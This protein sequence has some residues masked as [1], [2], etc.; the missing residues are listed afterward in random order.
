MKRVQ[1]RVPQDV[2]G[3]LARDQVAGGEPRTPAHVDAPTPN[4]RPT[5]P[6]NSGTSGFL[7][8]V[9][10]RGIGEVDVPDGG[11]VQA[12]SRSAAAGIG[13]DHPNADLSQPAYT[14]KYMD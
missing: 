4:E 8:P 13:P 14:R 6:T 9:G 11:S 1:G 7:T 2:D 12:V 5:K 10:T 3:F